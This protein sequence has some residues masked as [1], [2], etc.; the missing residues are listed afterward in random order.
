[1]SENTPIKEQLV[2]NGNVYNADEVHH[3]DASWHIRRG[4]LSPLLALLEMMDEQDDSIGGPV[5]TAGRIGRPLAHEANR[6]VDE[7][8]HN[9]NR[10][11]VEINVILST[12]K[13]PGV[14]KGQLLDV[15]IVKKEGCDH[16]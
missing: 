5:G 1:M 6:L 2:V 3:L 11:G 8:F 15:E 12:D 4:T 16:V 10:K 9:L 7:I 13:T 14:P